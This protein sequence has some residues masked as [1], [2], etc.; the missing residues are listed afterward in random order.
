MAKFPVVNGDIQQPSHL[1][2]KISPK[3]EFS[4]NFVFKFSAH[5]ISE[6]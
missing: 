4:S 6:K 3:G 1:S 5:L 2:P